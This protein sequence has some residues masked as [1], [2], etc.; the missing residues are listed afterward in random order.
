MTNEPLRPIRVPTTPE[1]TQLVR[2]STVTQ[3]SYP[4]P[5]RILRGRCRHCGAVIWLTP[6]GSV[7][8]VGQRKG[9]CSTTN[10]LIANAT[11]E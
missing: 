9:D 5:G 4:G 6:F 11:P 8:H 2:Q 7:L 3:H 10:A 1:W